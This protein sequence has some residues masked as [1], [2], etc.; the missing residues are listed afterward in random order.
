MRIDAFTQ[1]VL[2][3]SV[4]CGGNK[5]H[6]EKQQANNIITEGLA[7]FRAGG[8]YLDWYGHDDE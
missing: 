8:N 6:K 1:D 7:R 5:K 4:S 2:N 3:C